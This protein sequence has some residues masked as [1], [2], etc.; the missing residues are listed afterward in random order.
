MH[1]AKLFALV[2]SLAI[3]ATASPIRSE[4]QDEADTKADSFISKTVKGMFSKLDGSPHDEFEESRLGRVLDYMFNNDRAGRDDD[5][6]VKDELVARLAR[7]IPWWIP[8]S[9]P[10]ANILGPAWGPDHPYWPKDGED[11]AGLDARDLPTHE[12]EVAT[13]DGENQDSGEDSPPR[14]D[15]ISFELPIVKGYEGPQLLPGRPLHGH[16]CTPNSRCRECLSR[17]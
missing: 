6:P 12:V 1:G 7:D 13:A 14:T 8:V 10:P 2:A 17:R 16:F 15:G 5:R 11:A 3:I 4:E 9:R